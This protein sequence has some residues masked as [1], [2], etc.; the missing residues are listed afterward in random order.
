MGYSYEAEYRDEYLVDETHKRIWA[1]EINILKEIMRICEKHNIPYFV[2]GGTLLGAARHRGFIP[3]DDDMDVA[4]LRKDYEL[5]LEKADAELDQGRFCLQKSEVYGE[6]YEGFS[7]IRDNNSTAIIYRDRNKQCNHGIFVDIFPLDNIPEQLWKQKIQFLKIKILNA[8]IFYHVYA[9]E[10]LNHLM[11]KKLV[12]SIRNVKVWKGVIRKL[13]KEC[14]R[15][16]K[17]GCSIVGILSCAPY[18]KTCYW[19]LSDI[20]QTMDMEFEDLYVKVPVGYDR[21]LTIAY[22]NWREFPPVEERG[23]W[24]QNI[25]FDPYKPYTVYADGENM[26]ELF[27]KGDGHVPR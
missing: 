27:E 13:K 18:D 16:N 5:F 23:K 20:E 26:D 24:H 25:Y 3:W 2:Y 7:R 21:C 10:D 1:I 15:Y 19:Y 6:I 17:C 4:M 8:L 12:G 22:G 9:E 14:M 11:L